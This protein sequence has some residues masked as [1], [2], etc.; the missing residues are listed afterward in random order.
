MF[1]VYYVQSSLKV[2]LVT[3]P[4]SVRSVTDLLQQ[5]LTRPGGDL[6]QTSQEELGHSVVAQQLIFSL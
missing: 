1:A 5:G 3:M 4:V 6:Y 2:I